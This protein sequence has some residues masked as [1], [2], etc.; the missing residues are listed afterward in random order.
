MR[1]GAAVKWLDDTKGS[2]FAV[3]VVRCAPDSAVEKKIK[4]Q[5]EK[6]KHSEPD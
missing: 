4:R 2:A 5:W 6:T 1:A 3:G